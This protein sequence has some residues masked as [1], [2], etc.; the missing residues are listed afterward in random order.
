MT[1]HTNKKGIHDWLIQRLSAII[2]TIYSLFLIA[3]W[4][5]H[6]ELHYEHW[7][8]LYSNPWMQYSSLVALLSLMAHAWLGIWTV[9]TDYFKPSVQRIFIQ[10]LCM[11]GLFGYLIW[12]IHILRSIQ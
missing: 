5:L 11:T 4:L 6:P 7:H 1:T 8:T 3:Y 2:L 9:T 12:G 10:I